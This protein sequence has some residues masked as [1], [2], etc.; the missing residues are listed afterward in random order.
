MQLQTIFFSDHKKIQYLQWFINK[1]INEKNPT[2]VHDRDS[3]SS[4]FNN[5]TD[6]GFWN[7]KQETKDLWK[8]VEW[9]WR[10]QKTEYPKT[11]QARDQKSILI[12]FR[13]NKQKQKSKSEP[14]NSLN[15]VTYKVKTIYIKVRYM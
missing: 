8:R 12:G 5:I 9:K 7:W 13:S 6:E 1:I 10:Y 4:K 14:I 3:N 11:A 15:K 2:S